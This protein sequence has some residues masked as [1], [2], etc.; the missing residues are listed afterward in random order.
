MGGAMDG[1]TLSSALFFSEKL[2]RYTILRELEKGGM[3]SVDLALRDDADELCVIKRLHRQDCS[4]TNV[5]RRFHRE[6]K[7]AS[8]LKHPNLAQVIDAGLEEG[9][10]CLVSE[11]VPGKTLAS[12]RAHLT[13][14]KL[15]VPAD[16]TAF[17]GM[18]VL[19]ALDHVHGASAEDGAPLS[20]V[21]RDLSARNVMISFWGQVKVI[22]FGLAKAKVDDFQTAQGTLLGTFPY[23]S[24]EQAAGAELDGRSDLY[25]LS[26]ILFETLSGHALIA[27]TQPAE[28]L[29]KILRDPPPP[30]SAF[31]PQVPAGVRAAVIR[32]LAKSRDERWSSAREYREALEEAI[33]PIEDPS[34]RLSDS[35]RAIFPEEAR[36]MEALI[37]FYRAGGD[38][39]ATALPGSLS[40]PE[41]AREASTTMPAALVAAPRSRARQLALG[42]VLL[43]LGWLAGWLLLPA[44]G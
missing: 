7:L 1:L 14:K 19:S 15:L 5:V 43:A 27:R 2:G 24:P 12:Y 25:S 23:L 26:V 11:F 44:L 16:L 18:E 39:L 17:I 33:G 8:V 37:G 9:V 34:K 38:A 35:L 31:P 36:E 20:M 3:A 6:A 4:R 28:M 30:H 42:A 13:R 40:P 21:H 29:E 32:G 22:D 41:E 10:F